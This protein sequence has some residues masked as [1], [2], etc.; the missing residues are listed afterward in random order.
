MVAILKIQ[1]LGLEKNKYYK[2]KKFD[3]IVIG[4]G[5]AG[6]EACGASARLGLKTLLITSNANTIG[7][8]S[9]NPSIGGLGKGH[10]VKE[11]DALDG[12]MAKIID[13][14]CIQFRMLNRS[15]G[16]AVQGPRAQADRVLYKQTTQKLIKETKNLEVLEATA[17][18]LIIKNDV[19][20]GVVANS[21]N[22][23]AKSVVP[24]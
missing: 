13:S 17:T 20:E 16:V 4:G 8:L 19:I 21:E 5:H 18:D 14:A 2:M 9:C 3:V 12:Y 1:K 24:K 15:K 23:F 6:V 22:I 10:I 7:E 11:I